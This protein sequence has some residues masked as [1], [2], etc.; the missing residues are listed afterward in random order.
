MSRKLW[1]LAFV[2]MVGPLAFAAGSQPGVHDNETYGRLPLVFEENLG[3]A[4]GDAEFVSRGSG[5]SVFLKRGNATVH[6]GHDATLE[7]KLV[8]R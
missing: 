1:F 7:M 4:P 5:Y 8:T 2:L 3:Q 6:L